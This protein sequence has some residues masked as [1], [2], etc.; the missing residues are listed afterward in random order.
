MDDNPVFLF[1]SDSPH[2]L[3]ASRVGLPISLYSANMDTK[4]TVVLAFAAGLTGGIVSQRIINTP[5]YAQEPTPATKEIRAEKFVLVDDNGFPRGAFGIGTKDGWPTLE[6]IDKK[7]HLWRARLDD[8]SFGGGK[9]S[10]VP[11]K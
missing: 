1:L 5:V 3:P 4:A 11:P 8:P 6:V 7:G 2:S 10:V 9:P